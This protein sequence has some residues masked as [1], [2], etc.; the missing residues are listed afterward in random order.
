MPKRLGKFYP[1]NLI[2]EWV[3]EFI[4]PLLILRRAHSL[5][6][7]ENNFKWFPSHKQ[8]IMTLKPGYLRILRHHFWM[9]VIW[10]PSRSCKNS[11]LTEA[12]AWECVNS[13]IS[14]NKTVA[15]VYKHKYI[16]KTSSIKY[17]ICINW[18][19]II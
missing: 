5:S 14:N 2:T 6:L 18:S 7:A 12:F 13:F 8:A 4:A 9:N 16:L 17:V 1:F 15:K 3:M 19:D 10:D 11:I